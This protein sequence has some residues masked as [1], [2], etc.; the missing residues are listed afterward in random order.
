MG[1]GKETKC[2]AV[3]AVMADT[4]IYMAFVLGVEAWTCLCSSETWR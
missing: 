4:C 2:A 1:E 3:V